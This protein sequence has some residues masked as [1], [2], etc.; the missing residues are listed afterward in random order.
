MAIAYH[1][2]PQAAPENQL[3]AATIHVADVS[4][5]ILGIGVGIDGL[6]YPLEANALE[7]LGMAWEDLFQLAGQVTDELRHAKERILLD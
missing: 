3:L 2:E 7:H 6:R 5:M 4:M 1:H